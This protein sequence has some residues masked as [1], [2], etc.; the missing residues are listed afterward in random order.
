MLEVA[1]GDFKREEDG[2]HG[3]GDGDEILENKRLLG[4]AEMVG[5]GVASDLSGDS[6]DQGTDTLSKFLRQQ[7]EQQKEKLPGSFAP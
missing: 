1:V 2:S 7:R 5:H 4:H 3:D 6:S